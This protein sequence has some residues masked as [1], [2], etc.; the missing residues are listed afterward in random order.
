[1]RQ[2]LVATWWMK[3][4]CWLL[5]A[6]SGSS[7]DTKVATA[8]SAP[9]RERVSSCKAPLCVVGRPHTVVRTI[10]DPAQSM[11]MPDYGRQSRTLD[12]L[13]RVMHNK[14]LITVLLLAG[15]SFWL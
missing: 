4:C 11:G 12:A 10:D 8:L 5:L 9:L 7:I 3:T 15:L 13:L 2:R 1:M 14:D 6:D